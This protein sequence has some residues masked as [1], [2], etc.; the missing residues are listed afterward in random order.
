MEPD[1]DEGLKSGTCAV[2]RLADSEE[3]EFGNDEDSVSV[4]DDSKS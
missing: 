1:D 2:S 3:L 4:I